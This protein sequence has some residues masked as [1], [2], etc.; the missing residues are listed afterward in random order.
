MTKIEKYFR[1][2]NFKPLDA[3]ELPM[4][5]NETSFR[6]LGNG[7]EA[8]LMGVVQQPRQEIEPG[9]KFAKLGKHFISQIRVGDHGQAGEQP[10][11]HE[12]EEEPLKKNI[13][14]YR[15]ARKYLFYSPKR[16]D[17]ESKCQPKPNKITAKVKNRHLKIIC[18][19]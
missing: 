9:E 17:F 13:G 16:I 12:V 19:I 6:P 15:D 8:R 10:V 7:L 5:L 14:I 2:K 11:F 18:F 1:S 4:I 3:P